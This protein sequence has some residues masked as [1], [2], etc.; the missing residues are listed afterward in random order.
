M[1][2]MIVILFLIS[3]FSCVHSMEI[4]PLLN[5]P[6]SKQEARNYV[7]NILPTLKI[8][9]IGKS[10]YDLPAECRGKVI[11]HMSPKVRMLHR[12]MLWLPEENIKKQIFVYMLDGDEESAN[13]FYEMPV[14]QAFQVYHA[15]KIS[16]GDERKPIGPLFRLPQEKRNFI[17]NQL[18]PWHGNYISPVI[19]IEDQQKIHELDK[20][21]HQYFA[22]KEV[23]VLSDKEMAEYRGRNAAVCMCGTGMPAAIGFT[24]L[25]FYLIGGTEYACSPI[26]LGISLGAIP[27]LGV[28]MGFLG[29]SSLIVVQN[30][31]SSKVTL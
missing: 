14:L 29:L 25:V 12:V 30:N 8:S 10:Y 18:N 4:V 2:G 16:L 23:H 31:A 27:L 5:K 3:V 22:G 1:K 6:T 11:C 21:L 20:D 9:K 17:F 28:G 13:I 15:I 24:E 7:E 26:A 19:S